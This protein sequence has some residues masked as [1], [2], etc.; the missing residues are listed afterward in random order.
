MPQRTPQAIFVPWIDT[1][2]TRTVV[3]S[4]LN[5]ISRTALSAGGAFPT[6][7][8]LKRI[9][10]NLN[11]LSFHSAADLT[12]YDIT[13]QWTP[14][15]SGHVVKMFINIAIVA[16][17][18]TNTDEDITFDR[19]EIEVRERGTGNRLWMNSYTPGLNIFNAA[20]EERMFIIADPVD[21]RDFLVQQG[22]AVDIRLRCFITQDT[23]G[24]DPT[25]FMGVPD[26]F[27]LTADT[28]SKMFYESGIVFYVDRDRSKHYDST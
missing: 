5:Q 16:E 4:D 13:I 3:V 10:S 2:G 8:H 19:V 14:E 11:N 9:F 17:M 7:P 15:Y 27:P 21:K 22:V 18:P 1:T 25:F 12:A 23:G 20:N 26:I 24:T 28:N 6:D